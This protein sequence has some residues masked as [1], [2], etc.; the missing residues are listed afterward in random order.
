MSSSVKRAWARVRSVPG[1][2]RDVTV[3]SVL[4]ALA[5]GSVV[6]IESYLGKSYPWQ[7]GFALRAEFEQVP[8]LNPR[9]SHYVTIAGV[10][11]GEI[12]GAEP[13]ADGT[14]VVDMNIRAAD[15]REP[16][17]SDATAV[18]RAE[19]VL[20]EMY[21]E[22][23]PGT[24]AAGPM[25][26]G[27]TIPLGR[28]ARPIQADEVLGHLDERTR[29]ALSDLFVESDVALARAPELLPEGL[30]A[31]DDTV[32][33]L[34]PVAEALQTRRERIA[35][36]VTSL[37]QVAQSVGADQERTVA[38]ADATHSAL[39]VLA[40]SDAE[41]RGTLEQLPGLSGEL[42]NALTGTQRLTEQLDPTLDNLSAASEELPAALGRLGQT[43]ARLGEVV[44]S[45]GPFL[46][47]ARP[48][49][50]KLNPL[51]TDVDAALDDLLPVTS[52]LAEDI[53]I[54]QDYLTPI[55]A[56]TYNTSSVFGTRDGQ[57]GI[58]RGQLVV[59]LPDNQ[60]LPGGEPRNDP[61]AQNGLEPGPVPGK[62]PPPPGDDLPNQEGADGGLLGQI[63]GP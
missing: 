1:L 24:P 17:Y 21:V 56:F 9:S 50:A 22:I 13:T 31:T 49:V 34:R 7:D 3:L 18:L 5:L 28:T 12:K 16:I 10:S 37:S 59:S 55:R 15:Y 39:G 2:G 45:A 60:I 57:G 8:A 35:T 51:V 40:E 14:A 41:L 27:G 42:R 44:D 46:G 26:S 52:P 4:V 62:T 20:N 23:N 36:L 33:A 58:I 19:T 30:T 29:Q 61:G 53:A 25:E 6:G 63:G 38:L 43:S 11:V 48:V 32:V 54:V 47:K